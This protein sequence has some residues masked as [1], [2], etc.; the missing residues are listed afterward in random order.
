MMTLPF[1]DSRGVDNLVHLAGTQS[2]GSYAYG[3]S[4]ISHLRVLLPV[5]PLAGS[6]GRQARRRDRTRLS[7][8]RRRRVIVRS[9][10]VSA[11]RSTAAARVS[12]GESA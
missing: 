8:L 5:N 4:E 7:E 3:V 2:P 12:T 9:G 6:R 11:E 10:R 1:N